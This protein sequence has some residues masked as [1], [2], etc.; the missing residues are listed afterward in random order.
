MINIKTISNYL[1]D[2]FNNC[3]HHCLRPYVSISDKKIY[4]D[5]SWLDRQD[6]DLKKKILDFL[7]ISG[8]EIVYNLAESEI[9]EDMTLIE[10]HVYHLYVNNFDYSVWHNDQLIPNVSIVDLSLEKIK[11]ASTN[12]CFNFSDIEFELPKLQEEY[13]KISTVLEKYV[14][15]VFVRLDQSSAKHDTTLEPLSTAKDI[16]AQ[17]VNSKKLYKSIYGRNIEPKLIIMPWK[18]IDPKYEFRIFVLNKKIVAISQQHLYRKYNYTLGE[19]NNI[20]SAIKNVNFINELLYQ[21]VVCDVFVD[22]SNVCYL[23]ECNPYGPYSASGSSLFCWIKDKKILLENS[24]TI[25]FRF[26]V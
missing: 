4:L 13:Q 24:D 18:D 2:R 11:E 9:P 17:I 7:E 22:N 10:W 21:D 19:I 8:I 14:T 26:T 20:F 23:I 25:E 5:P 16:L 15:P 3:N 1:T 6:S 12:C